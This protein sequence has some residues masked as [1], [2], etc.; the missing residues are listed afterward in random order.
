M[1]FDTRDKLPALLY[2]LK[3]GISLLYVIYDCMDRDVYASG[4]IAPSVLVAYEHLHDTEE[5]L[6]RLCAE[7]NT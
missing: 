5:A 2:R 1:D 7:K 4:M 3:C 6:R